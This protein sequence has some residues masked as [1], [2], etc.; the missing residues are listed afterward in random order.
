MLLVKAKGRLIMPEARSLFPEL[1]ATLSRASSAQLAN[2]L[3]RVADLF[4]HG[5]ESFN[6]QHIAVFDDVIG[7]LIKK[8]ERSTLV[9]LSSR[10]APVANAPANVMA[11]LASHDDIAIAGPVLRGSNAITDQTLAEV[12]GTKSPRHLAAIAGRMLISNSVTD[13]LIARCDDETALRLAANKDAAFTE[14]GFVKLIKRARGNKALTSA[15]EVR[16]DLPSELQ[17]FLQVTLA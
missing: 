9:D 14:V 2:I 3:R 10:L 6:D 5:T 11:W 16:T 1:D 12:A 8:A 13:T 15:I 17:P 7:L 4:L